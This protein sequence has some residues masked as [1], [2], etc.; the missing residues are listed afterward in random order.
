MSSQQPNVIRRQSQS[1]TSLRFESHDK[2]L[3]SKKTFL[4]KS[5]SNGCYC[6]IMGRAF[7]CTD[8]L[9]LEAQAM[10]EVHNQPEEVLLH[11]VPVHTWSILGRHHQF[12]LSRVC[13]QV[14]HQVCSLLF[15]NRNDQSHI[16]SQDPHCTLDPVTLIAAERRLATWRVA[17]AC[18]LWIGVGAVRLLNIG[19]TFGPSP[20]VMF[21][22]R[23]SSLRTAR[24]QNGNFRRHSY[25][26]CEDVSAHPPYYEGR[27]VK[28]SS[29]V[30]RLKG[31]SYC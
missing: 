17:L 3:G 6:K 24:S 16:T 25:P 18:T 28:R 10:Y 8:V 30:L 13:P 23:P 14:T 21:H 5:L 22:D 19:S 11:Y 12:N 7:D 29:Y 1:S 4:V 15:C 9:R 2:T 31:F 20:L 27:A 26:V